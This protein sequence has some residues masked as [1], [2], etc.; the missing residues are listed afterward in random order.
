M[1]RSLN[2][3]GSSA[4][5]VN[6]KA[7]NGDF[8]AERRNAC[9]NLEKAR[10]IIQQSDIVC[11]DVDSTVIKEEGIDALAE[12]CGKGDEVARLTKEAMGGAMSFQEALQIRLDIIKPQQQQIQ[13]FLKRCPS[14]LTTNLPQFIDHL[15][16]NNKVIYLISGGFYSLIEPLAF[17]LKVPLTNIYANRLMFYYNGDYADFDHGQPT[18]R[19]GGKAEAI[20]SIRQRHRNNNPNANGEDVV[21]TMIGD[22][23]TD[24]EAVPPANYFIGFGG[25]V[26]RPEVH[27]RAQY[28]I[29]DFQQLMN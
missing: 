3:G 19:S 23:A 6:S 17:Q 28:Y 14:T 8:N 5:L 22:G 10:E 18:S 15:Q 26:L 9:K 13:N 16:K 11:F 7:Q 4:N 21:I 25:N 27:R 2:G 24:L 29:T 1:S 20:A 12:F